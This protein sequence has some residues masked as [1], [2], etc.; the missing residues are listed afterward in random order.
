MAT[1][2]QQKKRLSPK[3]IQLFSNVHLVD[4]CLILIMFILMIQSAFTLFHHHNLTQ[5]ANSIDIIVRTSTASI[6]GYFLSANFIR[7]AKE[8]A[9]SLSAK[10]KGAPPAPE[11]DSTPEITTDAYPLDFYDVDNINTEKETATAGRLQ[12]I[13]AATLGIFCLFTLIFMRNFVDWSAFSSGNSSNIAASSAAA[14][15]G[16]FRDFVSGCVGFLIGCPTS[17]DGE[18]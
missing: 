17:K 3:L 14:T 6:F 15:V 8:K 1:N 10:E 5:E 18:K 12:I 4:R 13:I 9:A 7:H 2:K 11:M 16:Q